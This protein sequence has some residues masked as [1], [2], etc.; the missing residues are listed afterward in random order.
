MLFLKTGFLAVLM[1]ERGLKIADIASGTGM[2]R[3]TI[4][5][6]MNHNAKGIQYDTFN[7]LTQLITP[8]PRMFHKYMEEEFYIKRRTDV[9][10][11]GFQSQC[12]FSCLYK[13]VCY[14]IQSYPF[15]VITIAVK[16]RLSMEPSVIPNGA[17]PII[18]NV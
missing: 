10:R 4:R 15:V 9:Y 13:L 5:S 3:T 7:T 12:W 11:F 8:I 18:V 16:P 2:S 1:A 17:S 14:F 6:L